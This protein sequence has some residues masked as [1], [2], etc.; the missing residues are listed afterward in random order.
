MRSFSSQRPQL[1][2]VP[3][4][5]AFIGSPQ[6]PGMHNYGPGQIWVARASD[7]Q[8]C[9]YSVERALADDTEVAALMATSGTQ[10][11]AL[12]RLLVVRDLHDQVQGCAAL[13]LGAEDAA[14]HGL[15]VARALRRRGL[16]TKL[17]RAVEREAVR[18]GRPLLRLQACTQQSA[19][20]ALFAGMGYGRCGPFP[21]SVADP[22]AVFMEKL[23]G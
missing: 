8:A 13:V 5:T 14:L 15:V 12:A 20:V 11:P 16:A 10:T 4:H 19:A 7:H 6:Q 22:S 3:L 1:G 2:A 17:M 18:A 23:L 9:G 21:G